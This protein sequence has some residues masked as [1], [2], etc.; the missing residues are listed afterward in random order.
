MP[1][2]PPVPSSTF[3]YLQCLP[4]PPLEGARFSD[5]ATCQLALRNGYFQADVH[6]GRGPQG[7]PPCVVSTAPQSPKCPPCPAQPPPGC[8]ARGC[9]GPWVPRA[10]PRGA[11]LEP[12]VGGI[13]PAVVPFLWAR[14]GL[15]CRG[16]RGRGGP[17]RHRDALFAALPAAPGGVCSSVG[18]GCQEGCV[19]LCAGCLPASHCQVNNSKTEEKN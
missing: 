7:H 10:S 14:R 8:W 6:I 15:S 3:Q 18:S 4:V 11:R 16:Q 17:S 2:V 12:R 13:S 1:A 5:T 19:P 9:H